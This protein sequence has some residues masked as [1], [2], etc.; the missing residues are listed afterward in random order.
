[1]KRDAF[2]YTAF[3][4]TSIYRYNVAREILTVLQISAIALF[5]S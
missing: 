5:L 1:M 3:F 2:V 4:P